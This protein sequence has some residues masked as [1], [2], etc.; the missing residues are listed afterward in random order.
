MKLRLTRKTASSGSFSSR[1]KDV[2]RLVGELL[3]SHSARE[4]GEIAI[5]HVGWYDSA[6]FAALDAFI[7]RERAKPGGGLAP[8]LETLPGYLRM[9][10]KQADEGKTQGMLDDLATG[11]AMD[12]IRQLEETGPAGD[13]RAALDEAVALCRRLVQI[14]PADN[15]NSGIFLSNLARELTQRFD[16][17]GAMGDLDEAISLVRRATRATPPGSAARADFLANLHVALRTKYEHTQVPGDRDKAID[18]ARLAAQGTPDGHPLQAN[19]LGG[20]GTA[21]LKRYDQTHAAKDAD[22]AIAT[23]R[24]AL[25]ATPAGD[26]EHDKIASL[27]GVALLERSGHGGRA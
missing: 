21:L 6:F 18:A 17:F 9:T 15:H 10:K 12:R 7:A 14:T 25:K 27:L 13:D 5:R 23:L 24:V 20:L 3:A 19:R 8:R 4:T 26:A 11:E 22:E 16:R 1:A 2:E